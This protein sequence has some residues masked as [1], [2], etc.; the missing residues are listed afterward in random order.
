MSTGYIW[1]FV[2]HLAFSLCFVCVYVHLSATPS[3]VQT[4]V[5]FTL[6]G[7]SGMFDCK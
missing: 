4:E 2:T 3:A 5:I 6:A 7:G 1:H